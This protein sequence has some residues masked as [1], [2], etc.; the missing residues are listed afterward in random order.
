[1]ETMPQRVAVFLTPAATDFRYADGLIRE[2]AA[3]Y[4]APLYEPHLTI[5]SGNA[6]D[7]AVLEQAVDEAT[8]GMPPLVLTVR[9][10][11]CTEEYFRTGILSRDETHDYLHG[12]D[13]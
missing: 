10:I 1:M 2:L 4:D 12:I 13:R 5:H 6:T 9:G 8:R 11:G 7:L 3:K